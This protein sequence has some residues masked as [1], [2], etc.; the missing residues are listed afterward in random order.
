MIGTGLFISIENKN[1]VDFFATSE[2]SLGID[3]STLITIMVGI[4]VTIISFLGCCGSCTNNKCMIYSFGSLIGLILI[5]EIVSSSLI[6]VY[7]DMV[8]EEILEV[9]DM[10]MQNYQIPNFE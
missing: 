8:Y 1:F 5:I 2:L 7:K 9:M 4:L 6:Y 3:V 10:G